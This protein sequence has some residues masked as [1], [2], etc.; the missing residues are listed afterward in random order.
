MY[1]V[2]RRS[3]LLAPLLSVLP[4]LLT[5]ASARAAPDPAKTII[6]PLG[7]AIGAAGLICERA[8]QLVRPPPLPG[9]EG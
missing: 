9:L 6:V 4:Q 7:Q 8:N 5:A 1:D 2:C 3:L